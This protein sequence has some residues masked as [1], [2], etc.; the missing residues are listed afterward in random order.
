MGLSF[1]ACAISISEGTGRSSFILVGVNGNFFPLVDKTDPTLATAFLTRPF[2]W[3]TALLVLDFLTDDFVVAIVSPLQRNSARLSKTLCFSAI[4]FRP[5]FLRVVSCLFRPE[6]AANQA[7]IHVPSVSPV[8]ARPIL[9]GSAPEKI[10]IFSSGF[11]RTKSSICVTFVSMPPVTSAPSA[12][13]SPVLTS[14]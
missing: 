5:L 8:R 4:A 9:P 3:G 10:W 7:E 2:F 14:L 6:L 13:P 1:P 12:L 11:C